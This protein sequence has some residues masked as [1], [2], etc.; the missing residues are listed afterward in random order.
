LMTIILFSSN[1]KAMKLK[2]LAGTI[3]IYLAVI[4]PLLI[5]NKIYTGDFL[6]SNTHQIAFITS[7]DDSYSYGKVFSLQT[8]L[9]WGIL[10]ILRSK[11]NAIPISIIEILKSFGREFLIIPVI[12]FLFVIL[13]KYAR[14]EIKSFYPPMLFGVL[15]F[16][17]YTFVA[18]F[19]ASGG[20][21]LRSGMALVPFGIILAAKAI[22]QTLKRTKR[23]NTVLTIITEGAFIG[24]VRVISNRVEFNNRIHDDISRIETIIRIN[25]KIS[26]EI[27]VMTRDPWEFNYE[28]GIRAI[29]IPYNDIET[30]Y[31][32]AS[33]YNVN[34][35][36]LPAPREALEP[37]YTS[38]LIDQRFE[39]LES[40]EGTKY[41]IFRIN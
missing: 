12:S 8:Y 18:T 24:C 25:H 26:D 15:L 36:I 14:F 32:V 7:H 23:V 38:K 13:K 37:I 20:A 5:I 35:L 1:D 11:L 22:H 40:V 16:L 27:I 41:R 30:I 31:Q 2:L 34:Y 28:T 29:Q 21:I 6:V 10:N 4:S 17:F 3:A 33:R 39:I 19:P 9:H